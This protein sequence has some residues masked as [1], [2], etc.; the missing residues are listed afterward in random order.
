MRTAL[1]AARAIA[2][3]LR[4]ARQAPGDVRGRRFVA[5]V[6]CIL[7]QN[8]RDCGA[9]RCAALDIDLV[10]LCHTHGVGILQMPCPEIAALGMLRCR[11]PELSLHAALATPAARGVCTQLASDIADRIETYLDAGYSLLAILGGNPRSP[12]CAVGAA[13]CRDDDGSGIFIAAL[14]DELRRR[15]RTVAFR[16]IRDSNPEW[17]AADLRWL[18]AQFVRPAR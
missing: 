13:D 1:N 15:Q 18:E 12:G 6:D 5:V 17:H 10:S 16:G 8:S 3:R 11:P 2:R 7:N 4:P 9:A 14:R